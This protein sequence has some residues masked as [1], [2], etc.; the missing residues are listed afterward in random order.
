M[1]K[2]LFGL[3]VMPALAFGLVGCG[4]DDD[5]LTFAEYLDQS[6][7][8]TADKLD[9]TIGSID[10]SND[11]YLAV[12]D[13]TNSKAT[14]TMGDVSMSAYMWAGVEEGDNY[15]YGALPGDDAGDY[16]VAKINVDTLDETIEAAKQQ[17]LSNEM[18]ALI[19]AD[20]NE[21]GKTEVSEV[22]N[23]ALTVLGLDTEKVNLDTVLSKF[24]FDI[25]DFENKGNGVYKLKNSALIDIVKEIYKE[26]TE[27][28]L[29][30]P[31]TTIT[32]IDEMV[33]VEVKYAN[34]HIE[35]VKLTVNVNEEGQTVVSTG[36]F[37]FVY[38]GEE[39]TKTTISTEVVVSNESDD[40]EPQYTATKTVVGVNEFSVEAKIGTSKS[41]IASEMLFSTKTEN[42]KTTI[43]VKVVQCEVT[44]LDATVG[45]IGSWISDG[46]ISMVTE[47][48]EMAITLESGVNVTIPEAAKNETANDMTE[49]LLETIAGLLDDDSSVQ[50]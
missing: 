21:S 27:Q 11:E 18:V 23:N 26:A 44:L 22:V 41:E 43:K 32:A 13:I 30:I 6:Q 15:I 39:V 8:L 9:G 10:L 12:L 38:S 36:T 50:E 25:N 29:E 34:E 42:A 20:T 4:K 45:V 17:L 33:N 16:E 35:Q 46:T 37:D 3:M 47:E 5:S 28:D 7:T 49:Y 40:V 2:K 48:G 31:E 14:V 19:I 24:K 1:K